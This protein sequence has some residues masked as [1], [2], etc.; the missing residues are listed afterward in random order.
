MLRRNLWRWIA[1]AMLAMFATFAAAPATSTAAIKHRPAPPN[2][3]GWVYLNLN[4][5]PAGLACAAVYRD[6]TTAYSWT[7]SAWRPTTLRQGWVYVYPY[8]GQWRWTW[9]QATGWVAAHDARFE[10][11]SY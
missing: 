8:T 10:I 1:V 6:S 5:C 2:H 9:T 3:V 11:R 7:G 4:H